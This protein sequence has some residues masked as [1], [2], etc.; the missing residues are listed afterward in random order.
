MTWKRHGIRGHIGKNY[1]KL[2]HPKK[3]FKKCSC[4]VKTLFVQLLKNDRTIQNN[5]QDILKMLTGSK[6]LLV[7]I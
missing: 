7:T 6:T 1:D 3:K 2:N 4:S 5:I